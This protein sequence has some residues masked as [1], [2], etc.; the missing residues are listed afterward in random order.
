MVLSPTGD[1]NSPLLRLASGTPAG[2]PV[3]ALCLLAR[4]GE[5]T[6]FA[7][8]RALRYNGLTMRKALISLIFLAALAGGGL[9]LQRGG[10]LDGMMTRLAGGT[11]T[12]SKASNSKPTGPV[13][14]RSP[15]EVAAA[16][17]KRMSDDISAIGTLLSDESVQ[18]SSETSGRIDEILFKDGDEVVAGAVLIKLDDAL[19]GAQLADARARLKLAQANYD[20]AS[21]LRKSGNAAQ[22]TLDQTISEL[23]VAQS[24]LDLVL[25]QHEKLSIKAPFPGVLGFRSV[26]PGAYV[27]AGSPLVNLEKID[28][29]KVTFSVPEFY[30]ERLTVGQRV[31]IAADAMPGTKFEGVIYAIDPAIDINGRAIKVRATLDNRDGR[32]RPGLLARVIVKGSPRDA[33]TV[34]EAALVPR[35][36]DL[37][38]YKA[39]NGKALEIKVRT[40]RRESGFVE[41]IDG[42]SAGDEVVTAGQQ[43]LRDGSNVEIVTSQQA[44]TES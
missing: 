30:L 43:R 19:L 8:S 1:G 9:Y 18:I 5:P 40:G 29:L 26:S 17:V 7:K 37:L 38:I 34:P 42:I 2:E 24:V 35:G 39:N 33:V 27:T 23:A 11:A 44:A 31:E 13:G 36:N 41:I 22:S 25:A 16:A 32:L 21:A 14:G 4:T 28:R 12:A 10:Y 6:D 15:V 3:L 20:R